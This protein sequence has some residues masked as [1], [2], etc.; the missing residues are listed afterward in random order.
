MNI[1]KKS[2]T[3]GLPAAAMEAFFLWSGL[4]QDEKREIVSRLPSP[5]VFEKGEVIT[6]E[7]RFLRSLAVILNGQ[8]EVFRTGQDGRRVMMNRLAAGQMFGAASLF[9][10][11][12]E[13]F[14]EI[15]VCRPAAIL[16]I[17]QE[18]MGE[19]IHRY[20]AVAENYIRFLTGRIRFLNQ[21]IA[22]FTNGTADS[23]LYRYLLDQRRED[24]S[25]CLPRSMVELAQL[26]NIGRSS[27]YRSLDALTAAGLIRREGKCL[28]MDDPAESSPFSERTDF[29]GDT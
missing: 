17:S 5:L 6:A 10:E 29:Q 15:S 14:T 9:G 11:T 8:V 27:L 13:Y 21:K 22:A 25:V 26:L 12:E 24:G 19:L 2:D 7:K 18:K 28:F 20:P 3:T 16:F 23:R 4:S 1:A